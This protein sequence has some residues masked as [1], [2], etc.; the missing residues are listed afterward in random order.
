M[1]QGSDERVK[2]PLL[3]LS[4]N[5]FVV[6]GEP[7]QITFEKGPDGEITRVIWRDIGG[8]VEVQERAR[9]AGRERQ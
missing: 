6:R 8:S 1:A 4:D 3:A 7:A 9:V 5:T 2:T